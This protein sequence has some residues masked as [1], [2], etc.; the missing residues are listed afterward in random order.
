[1]NQHPAESDMP[2]QMPLRSL[3]NEISALTLH[4]QQLSRMAGEASAL[5]DH[6]QMPGPVDPEEPQRPNVLRGSGRT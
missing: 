3:L 1:M 5:I 4:V 6:S 2:Q